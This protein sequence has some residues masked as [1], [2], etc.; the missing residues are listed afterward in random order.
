MILKKCKVQDMQ[1]NMTSARDLDID[2]ARD[3]YNKK[4]IIRD[5]I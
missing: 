1:K 4:H 3:F 5:A 2:N